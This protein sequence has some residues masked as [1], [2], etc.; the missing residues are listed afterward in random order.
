M[1]NLVFSTSKTSLAIPELHPM[2]HA[3]KIDKGVHILNTPVPRPLELDTA[4]LFVF[5]SA[6]KAIFPLDKFVPRISAANKTWCISAQLAADQEM[7]E[8]IK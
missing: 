8:P 7:K 6:G 4:P 2:R 1:I 5:E 3:T